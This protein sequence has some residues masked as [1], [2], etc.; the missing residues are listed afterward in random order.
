MRDEL[1]VRTIIR[2][3]HKF[4]GSKGGSAR[5]EAQRL[6]RQQNAAKARQAKL[7]KRYGKLVDELP[8]KR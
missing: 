6:A 8:S 1:D 7:L 3:H 5:T 2:E 4:I